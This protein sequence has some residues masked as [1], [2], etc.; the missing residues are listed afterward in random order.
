MSKLRA[1]RI[2]MLKEMAEKTGG[3]ITTSQI[4]KAGMPFILLGLRLFFL[5]KSSNMPLFLRTEK[6]SISEEKSDICLE[7]SLLAIYL[8]AFR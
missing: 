7:Y 6:N 8:S 3:M 5:Q 4:E 2:E 1:Q